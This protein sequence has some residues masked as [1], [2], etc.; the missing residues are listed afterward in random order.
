MTPILG[1]KLIF[2]SFNSLVFSG[3]KNEILGWE[4]EICY[5]CFNKKQTVLKKIKIKQN[6]AP[7]EV[8]VTENNFSIPKELNIG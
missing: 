7:C 4:R 6:K 8:L 1:S 2:Q 5:K 3:V